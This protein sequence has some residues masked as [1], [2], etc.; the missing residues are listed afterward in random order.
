MNLTNIIERTI[1][2]ETIIEVKNDEEKNISDIMNFI[3]ILTVIDVGIKK[4]FKVVEKVF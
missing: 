2:H 1:E 3:K 4:I